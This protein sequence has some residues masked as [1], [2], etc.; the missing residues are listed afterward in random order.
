MSCEGILVGKGQQ[1]SVSEGAT[2]KNKGRD[3]SPSHLPWGNPARVGVGLRSVRHAP[4]QS[5]A[6]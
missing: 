6:F 1:C 4:G 3:T 2:S 5:S